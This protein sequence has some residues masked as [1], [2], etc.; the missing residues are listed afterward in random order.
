MKRDLIPTFADGSYRAIIEP[1]VVFDIEED[2]AVGGWLSA[3]T[4]KDSGDGL[5]TGELGKFA[6]IRF[7][8]ST[9]AYVATA[10]GAGGIDVYSTFIFGP[11][12]YTFGDWGTITGHVVM[13]GGHGDEL[14]Q[15]ASVGWKGRFGAMILDEAGPRY[16]RIE[17]ASDL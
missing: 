6:G 4:Y 17:S 11:E 3:A 15:V 5:L 7:I 2:D 12:A 13:P 1:G 8:E 14:A 16:L 9:H 10:G